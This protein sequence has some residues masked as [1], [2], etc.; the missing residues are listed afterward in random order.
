M[1]R[2]HTLLLAVVAVAVV[3]A[4][5]QNKPGYRYQREGNRSDRAGSPRAGLALLGGG[6]DLDAAFQWMCRR[7]GGGDF[8][9]LR[10]SGTAAYNPYIRKLCPRMNSVATLIIRSRAAAAAPFVA[11]R[12]AEASAIF[13]SGG[14]QSHYVNWWTGTPVQRALDA[15]IARGVP[16]GG[17]SAGLAVLGEFAYSAQHDRADGP[18]LTAA[19]A[20]A[21]PFDP[22]VVVVR[23]FLRI[24]AMRG[25]ITDTHFHARHR[26]GRLLVFMA[27]ILAAQ[28]AAA[29]HG[30]GIDQH[31]ALL[32]DGNGHAV[33]A[34]TGAVYL[35]AAAQAPSVCRAGAPLSFAPIAVRR[36]KAGQRFDLAAWQG[37]GARYTLRVRRGIITSTQA[38][39][40]IY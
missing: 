3:A 32:V 11:G 10:A 40:N 35:L 13:I 34:G 29:I 2:G 1:V 28:E 33:V 19:A 5:A 24:P 12:I 38:N 23:H 4:A 26:L 39:G 8:L 9:V 20:L 22:Q 17:T 15:A 18:N 16:I 31:T 21:N 7:A 27:R 25:V 14:D 36:L 37:A 6:T 30:I